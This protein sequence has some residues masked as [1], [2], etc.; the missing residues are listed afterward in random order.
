MKET[1]VS[2]TGNGIDGNVQ[3]TEKWTD[4]DGK[5]ESKTYNI[6]LAEYEK[7]AS[8]QANK[9]SQGMAQR[10]QQMQI[11]MNQTME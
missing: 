1:V 2:Y 10:H 11:Y 3:I 5:L 6:S 9:L 8:A 4:K 7:K